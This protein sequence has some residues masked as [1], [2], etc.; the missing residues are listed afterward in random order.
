MIP[1]PKVVWI[2]FL[3]ATFVA[4]ALPNSAHAQNAQI[5]HVSVKNAGGSTDIGIQTSRRLIP[6]TQILTDPDRLVIDF[7]DALPGPELRPVAVNQGEVKS[8][9]ASL[10]SSN[11]SMTRV[12][13]ELKSAT[14]FQ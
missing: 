7:P 5:R 1:L 9:R 2:S 3:G 13:V 6:M 4:A 12:V 10:F 8:V 14:D 11:P